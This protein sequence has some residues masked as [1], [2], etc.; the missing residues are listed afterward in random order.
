MEWRESPTPCIRLVHSES[1]YKHTL[2]NCT[3]HYC[4]SQMFHVLQIGDLWQLCVEQV[5]QHHF[6]NSICSLHVSMSHLVILEVFHIFLLSLYLLWWSVI[7]D[8]WCTIV[9]VFEGHEPHPY[10]RRNLVSVVWV[11]T[12]P[13]AG[14]SPVSLRLLSSPFSM[15]CSNIKI[16]PMNNPTMTCKCSSERKSHVSHVKSKARND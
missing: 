13:Q 16:R 11:L 10:K 6:S 9:F 7:S 15:G 8:L 3:F 12:A 4:A 14:H 2:F 5:Y 1:V